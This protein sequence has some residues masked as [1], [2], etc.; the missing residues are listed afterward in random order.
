MPSRPG[1]RH[2]GHSAT[3]LFPDLIG[4]SA[5]LADPLL[6]TPAVPLAT[7]YEPARKLRDRMKTRDNKRLIEGSFAGWW[8]FNRGE[9]RASVIAAMEAA[10]ASEQAAAGGGIP[11][12]TCGK[13]GTS[14]REV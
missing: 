10:A 11:L 14:R 9:S 7:K 5:P 13:I 1:P 6:D 2:C 8:V 12:Y 3:E 4:A